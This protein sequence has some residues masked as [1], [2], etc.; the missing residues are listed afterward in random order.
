MS[1][2]SLLVEAIATEGGEA[3]VPGIVASLRRSGHPRVP[4][5]EVE[6]TLE[7]D[8]RFVSDRA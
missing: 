6:R 8:E 4:R 3:T 1:V 2:A 7:R 5:A